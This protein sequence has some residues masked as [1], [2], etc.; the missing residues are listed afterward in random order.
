MISGNAL[1]YPSRPIG[2]LSSITRFSMIIEPRQAGQRR[3]CNA[4]ST[5]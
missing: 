3:I 4:E 5:K 2:D 1:F